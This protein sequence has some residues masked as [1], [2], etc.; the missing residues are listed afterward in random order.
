MAADWT[1]KVEDF[2]R[3]AAAEVTV[4]PLTVLVGRNNSG[5]SYLATLIWGLH[6]GQLET[7]GEDIGCGAIIDGWLK[8]A[9]ASGNEWTAWTE[10]EQH[11]LQTAWP[12]FVDASIG[13]FC[14]RLFDTDGIRPAKVSVEA[15]GFA[16]A[17]YAKRIGRLAYFSTKP[18]VMAG[19]LQDSVDHDVHMIDMGVNPWPTDGTESWALTLLAGH[20]IGPLRPQYTPSDAVYLPASRTGFSL[21]LSTF[22]EARVTSSLTQEP[23]TQGSHGSFTLPHVHLLQALAAGF[24]RKAGPFADEAIRL[25]RE[26]LD[27]TIVVEAPFGVANYR[28]LPDGCTDPIGLQHTSALV[29][30]LMP[31]IVALRY[32]QKIPF[33]VLEEPEAHLHP[34]LQRAVIRCLARLVRRGVRVLIT[35]HSATVAQQINNLIKLE[36]LD[37]EQRQRFGYDADEHLRLDEVAMHELVFRDDGRTVSMAAEAT[38]AGFGLPTLNEALYEFARETLDLNAIVEPERDEE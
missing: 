31:L 13:D 25:E 34:K 38:P 36:S 15:P 37:P 29:T 22:I 28:F 12:R 30:E 11:A 8:R 9:E 27:G 23:R 1:L 20:S 26:C 32:A 6:H 2:G 10:D 35:T 33:L 18:G 3:I 21:F 16:R 7:F 4:K 14:R 24:R 5:K 17:W 19:K